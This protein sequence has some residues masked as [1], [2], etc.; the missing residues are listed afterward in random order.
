MLGNERFGDPKNDLRVATVVGVAGG[1]TGLRAKGWERDRV[2]DVRDRVKDV[3][4]A[5]RG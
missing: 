2:K 5:R 3:R 1:V 4:N